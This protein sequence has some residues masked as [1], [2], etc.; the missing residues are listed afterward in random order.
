VPAKPPAGAAGVEDAGAGVASARDGQT[1]PE[2]WTRVPP[3]PV[4]L[5]STDKAADL[6]L[7]EGA[8]GHPEVRGYKGFRSA[9][10][11]HGVCEGD[12]Y[13]EVTVLPVSPAG[14]D[15]AVRAGWTTRRSDVEGP[16]GHDGAGYGI[17]DR[18]GQFVFRSKLESYGKPYGVGD[19][20]GCRIRLPPRV[21]AAVKA[22]MAAADAAWLE[23]RFVRFLQNK[24]PPD[25]GE[26]LAGA[27]VEFS[28]NGQPFGMP[29]YFWEDRL[30]GAPTSRGMPA[31]VYFPT[32]SLFKGGCARVNFG[33]EFAHPLPSGSRP[34]AECAPP[35]AAAAPEC[36][37]RPP[38]LPSPPPVPP[39]A[40]TVPVPAGAAAKRTA[41]RPAPEVEQLPGHT[42]PSPLASG[43]EESRP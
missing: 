42:T 16:V 26:T 29:E 32:V 23:C 24:P 5:S 1:I 21:D 25:S 15:G 14:A 20:M 7:S 40:A 10:A 19:V 27:F 13:F 8:D 12:W 35:P 41:P 38:P 37:P 22:K 6:P 39:S 43:L 34:Y 17:R 18:S 31:A 4:R 11:T 9:R 36:A 2:V 30:P 3:G 28:K 33:P